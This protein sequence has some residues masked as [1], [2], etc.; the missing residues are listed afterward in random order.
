MRKTDYAKHRKVSAGRISQLIAER[1][2]I[3]LPDGKVDVDASD[4]LLD[5]TTDFARKPTGAGQQRPD[6]ADSPRRG[7]PARRDRRGRSYQD[8]RRDREAWKAK[9]EELDY[10]REASEL[11]E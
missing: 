6:D 11:V 8:E 2:I 3:V 9:R 1:R 10:R 5:A 4:R 7:R